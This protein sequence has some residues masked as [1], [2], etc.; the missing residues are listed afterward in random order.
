MALTVTGS[1]CHSSENSPLESSEIRSSVLHAL[2]MAIRIPGVVH[3]AAL[4]H[5]VEGRNI[6]TPMRFK[7]PRMNHS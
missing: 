3:C 2:L 6:A 7:I 4:V 1:D 5:T